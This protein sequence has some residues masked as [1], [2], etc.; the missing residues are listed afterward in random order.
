MKVARHPAAAGLPGKSPDM[1]RPVGSVRA[2]Y[3]RL[4]TAQDLK[5]ILS[6]GSRGTKRANA[7]RVFTFYGRKELGPEN[8]PFAR[9]Y[10]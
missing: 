6:I 5:E 1:I 10:S 3:P 7:Y 8:R 9:M 2:G 4:M